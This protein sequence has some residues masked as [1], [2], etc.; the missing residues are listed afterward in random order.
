MPL[1]YFIEMFV[2]F[3]P[4]FILWEFHTCNTICF[5]YIHSPLYFLCIS[6]SYVSMG[7]WLSTGERAT[8][9]GH[10]P[11]ENDS[12]IWNAYKFPMLLSLWAPTTFFEG[13]LAGTSCI[14]TTEFMWAAAMP[15]QEDSP[16]SHTPTLNL[17][18]S[19]K[20]CPEPLETVIQMSHLGA[21]TSQ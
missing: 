14:G 21:R 19:S 12:P 20:V 13:V 16:L 11:K 15:C 10:N 1:L 9:S 2:L 8:Y 7:V 18:T 4:I 3:F 6:E 5:D 17:S